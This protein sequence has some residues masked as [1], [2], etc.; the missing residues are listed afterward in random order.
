MLLLFLRWMKND[1]DEEKKNIEKKQ[2]Q[3]EIKSLA[4]LLKSSLLAYSLYLLIC[5]DD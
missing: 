5:D 4:L 2:I 1:D 3:E